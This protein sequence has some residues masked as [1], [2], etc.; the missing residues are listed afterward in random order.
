L[1][2][3]GDMTDKI[4]VAGTV[5]RSV[6]IWHIETGELIRR[7]EGHTGV[8]FDVR[9]CFGDSVASVSDDRSVRFWPQALNQ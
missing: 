6:L 2:Y 3:S 7:L 5:F 8:I 9:V 1:L 4:V